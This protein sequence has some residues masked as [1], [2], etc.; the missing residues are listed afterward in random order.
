MGGFGQVW[1]ARQKLTG[2]FYAVKLIP[3]NQIGEVELDGIRQ[4]KQRSARD[5]SF[6]HLEH[7]GEAR[8]FY[9][10]VMELA[11]DAR[12][13]GIRAPEEYEPLTLAEYLRLKGSLG[14]VDAVTIT[15]HVLDTLQ[16]LHESG[17]LHRDIKP[18][19]VLCIKGRWK[20][21]D[22]GLVAQ[23]RG[24]Q[25]KAGTKAYGPPEGVV[26]RTGDFYSAGR[27]LC[28]LL[29]GVAPSMELNVPEL[30]DWVPAGKR[31][32]LG[33]VLSRACHKDPRHRF[34]SASV[35]GKEL[36][37][38]TTAGWWNKSLLI[39]AAIVVAIPSVYLARRSVVPRA[40]DMTTAPSVPVSED[41]VQPA[42]VLPSRLT[43]SMKWKDVSGKSHEESSF[44]RPKAADFLQLY[45]RILP[46]QT[47]FVYL[48]LIKPGSSVS[49]EG[50]NPDD[51]DCRPTEFLLGDDGR[52]GHYRH[53]DGPGRYIYAAV[54]TDR[55]VPESC[56]ELLLAL[57]KLG[58]GV[59]E[60][61]LRTEAMKA[62]SNHFRECAMLVCEPS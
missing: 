40:T 15:C 52:F 6:L 22:L 39:S 43:L 7:V 60:Q 51:P 8:D 33:D 23:S 2:V 20:L 54:L 4:Y 61:L 41:K 38:I 24:T 42:I 59:N 10:Y 44:C 9:Y 36:K 18:S 16:Q 13:A 50:P 46:D 25:L 49:Y 19:N 35:F 5:P 37:Q 29:T 34:R 21:G 56:K 45:V 28:E 14:L 58:S 62:C 27:M 32:K 47:G 31:R 1:L 55:P 11:D 57:Q 53:D 12:G 17:L 26:D 3:K 48:F 30:P